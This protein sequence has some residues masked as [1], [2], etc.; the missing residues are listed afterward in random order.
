[1]KLTELLVTAYDGG[2]RR[3]HNSGQPLQATT[4][5]RTNPLV[6]N[7]RTRRSRNVR[8]FRDL[9]WNPC[10]IQPVSCVGFR[11]HW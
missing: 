9:A 5:N 6:S 8:C 7:R 2:L 3:T 4:S 11:T 1:M 10:P